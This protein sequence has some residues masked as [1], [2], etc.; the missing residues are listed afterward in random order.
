MILTHEQLIA[1]TG[2][3]RKDA[4]VKNLRFMGIE[5]RL[6]PDGSIAV[7]SAHVEQVLGFVAPKEARRESFEPNWSVLAA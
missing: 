7:S 5:Y 3:S 1:L 4:Q 2:R 6:R